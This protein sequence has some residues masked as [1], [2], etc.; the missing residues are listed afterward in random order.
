MLEL[1]GSR[2]VILQRPLPADDPRQ[3]QPDITLAKTKLNW[4]PKVQLEQGLRLTIVYFDRLLTKAPER[5]KL[6][7]ASP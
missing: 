2:S 6:V 4:A 3:R 1:T 7:T 5:L